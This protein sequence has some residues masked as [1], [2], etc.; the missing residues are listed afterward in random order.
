M[1]RP[2]Y[3]PERW[4]V[5]VERDGDGDTVRVLIPGRLAQSAYHVA[6]V[7]GHGGDADTDTDRMANARLIAAAPDLLAALRFVGKY[8][9]MRADRGDP[10]PSQLTDT[11]QAAIARAEGRA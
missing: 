11:V 2:A 6:L 4:E 3:A 1:T 5:A 8:A 9:A 10:L 7:Y